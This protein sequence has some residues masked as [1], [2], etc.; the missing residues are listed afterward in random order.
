LNKIAAILTEHG[1]KYN[2]IRRTDGTQKQSRKNQMKHNI[3][4]MTVH[5]SKGLECDNVAI[6]GKFPVNGK[7]DS[8]EIKVYYV[9][10]TRT[11]SRC[12]V[13]V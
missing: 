10:L 9:A 12:T 6:Y 7:G 8:D 2:A 1:I 4:I 5:T 13:F 11:I 3:S